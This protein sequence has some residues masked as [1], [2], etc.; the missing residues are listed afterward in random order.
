MS[1]V[2]EV[3]L[4]LG[5]GRLRSVMYL[6][7]HRNH[8]PEV[9]RGRS[10]G[11]GGR[12]TRGGCGF[13]RGSIGRIEFSVTFRASAHLFP[14]PMAPSRRW[15][16]CVAPCKAHGRPRPRVFATRPPPG[17][18]R[19]RDTAKV[20]QTTFT[21]PWASRRKATGERA[22][23]EK[24]RGELK[25]EKLQRTLYARS[26]RDQCHNSHARCARPD[27]RCYRR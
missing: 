19:S 22:P 7:K 18:A 8:I 12:S 26:T 13:D 1:G 24:E 11:L 25:L 17:M 20:F 6:S 5:V 21:G 15:V 9:P 10:G 16:A 3:N 4:C 14:P 2:R 27:P 23:C